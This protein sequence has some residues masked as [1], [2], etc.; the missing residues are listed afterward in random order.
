[1]GKPLDPRTITTLDANAD[2]R[3]A[4]GQG[5]AESGVVNKTFADDSYR[6]GPQPTPILLSEVVLKILDRGEDHRQPSPKLGRD[7]ALRL[8][9]AWSRARSAWGRPTAD[10]LES[11]GD[12]PNHV[13]LMARPT[14][15]THDLY[16]TR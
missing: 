6:K 9:R 16:E 12:N 13:F 3:I 4:L 11:F 15:P 8:W 7:V 14:S 10:L 1:M 2:N 5:E